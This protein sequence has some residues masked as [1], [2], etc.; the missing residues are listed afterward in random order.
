MARK[1]STSI[2]P[3]PQLN[4]YLTELGPRTKRQDGVSALVERTLER[5]RNIVQASLPGWS[6]DE[7]LVAVDIL[8]GGDYGSAQGVEVVGLALQAA[9]EKRRAAGG[10]ESSEFAYRAKTLK[11]AERVAVVEVVERYRRRHTTI[12][13]DALAALLADISAPL[14][15]TT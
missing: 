9:I 10:T 6:V 1:Y 5:Y 3:G 11:F 8:R 14:P 7:W 12:D 4:A 15:P 2:Y 13:R